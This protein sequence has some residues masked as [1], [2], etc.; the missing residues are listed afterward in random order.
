MPVTPPSSDNMIEMIYESTPAKWAA[1]QISTKGYGCKTVGEAMA[2]VEA[3]VQ[4]AIEMDRSQR[5][6][7]PAVEVVP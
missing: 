4:K 7:A 1:L 3:I 5:A 2:M 6:P